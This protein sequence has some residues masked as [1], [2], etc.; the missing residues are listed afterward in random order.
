MR[1]LGFFFIVFPAMPEREAIMNSERL[2]RIADIIPPKNSTQQRMVPVSRSTWW[3]GVK[4]GRFPKP[5]KLGPRTTCWRESDIK[6]LLER[7]VG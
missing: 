4:D 3:Q 6:D 5:V 7:G 1:F 2:L